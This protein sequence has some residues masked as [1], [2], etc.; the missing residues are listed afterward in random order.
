MP[1][2][3]AAVFGLAGVAL[4][5]DERA[6]FRD[7]DPLG[8][9]LF[10][11]NVE[12]PDQVRALVAGLRAAVGRADAP[13][14]IDQEGGRVARLRPP[15]WRAAPPAKVFGDLYARKPEAAREATRLNHRLLAAELD[16][17]GITV[18]CAPVLDVPVAG[19]HDVI[20]D[21]AF[22]RDPAVVADLG[23]AACEG[24]LAGGVL[25]VVKHV[26]GHGRARAD[27]HKELP[28][29]DAPLADLRASDFAP[30]RMLRDAPWAMTAHVL[31]QSLDP[32]RPA[33]QSPTVVGGTIRGEIGFDGVLVS[34][35]I[36]M[37]ALSGGFRD[38]A[39]ASLRAGC[40][41]VLHCSGEMA[42]MRAAAEGTG[43]LSPDAARRVARAEALRARKIEPLAVAEASARLESLLA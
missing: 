38:R 23:R 26:P 8:F 9:I 11:R 32:G 6:F 31:Y 13:V 5:A 43:P 41:V 39:E 40:D 1:F 30:F 27:S 18:D 21:R 20:G 12:T 33:T 17:L 4:T 16:A 10:A 14:L 19:A 7:A 3:R 34:D 15:H 2:P 28:A 35:D 25:P 24:L 22:S 36:G 29:V 42:E 37:N